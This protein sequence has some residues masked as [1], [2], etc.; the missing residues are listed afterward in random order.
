MLMSLSPME[1]GEQL[2]RM[3]LMTNDEESELG[4][5]PLPNGDVRIFRDNGRDGL[6][7]LT[8][9]ATKYSHWR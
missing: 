4:T 7:F 3:Y 2:V 9:Q 5:T 6:T 1:Y 8:Q